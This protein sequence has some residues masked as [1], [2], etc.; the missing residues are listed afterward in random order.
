MR[1]IVVPCHVH[2]EISRPEGCMDYDFSTNWNI[3]VIRDGKE[4]Y[5]G[6]LMT[7]LDLHAFDDHIRIYR[8]MLPE[9]L[10]CG[11]CD[12]NGNEIGRSRPYEWKLV[13]DTRDFEREWILSNNPIDPKDLKSLTGKTEYFEV[14]SE[15]REGRSIKL[16]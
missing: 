1:F 6:T 7:F 14:C 16:D 10:L 2:S 15:Y 12:S 5:S 13:F 4:S 11:R 3:E 8:F 9:Y